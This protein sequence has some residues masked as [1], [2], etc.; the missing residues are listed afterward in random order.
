MYVKLGKFAVWLTAALSVA[1]A[2][3]ARSDVWFFS[4]WLVF[5]HVFVDAI[6]WTGLYDEWRA[7]HLVL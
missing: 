3:C 2:A 4:V 1:L 7:R 6:V 5:H